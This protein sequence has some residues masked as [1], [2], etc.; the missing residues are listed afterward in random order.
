MPVP[1]TTRVE[2]TADRPGCATVKVGGHM[3]AASS[4]TLTVSAEDIPHLYVALPVV[5]GMAVIV[6]ARTSLAEESS[7]ALVAM[8][9]TPPQGTP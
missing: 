2:I 3:L 7:A 5:D 6:D 4:A 9:W 8:G 1:G